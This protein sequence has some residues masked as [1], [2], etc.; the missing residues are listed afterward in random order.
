VFGVLLPIGLAAQLRRGGGPIATVQQLA[1]ITASL[2]IATLLALKAHEWLLVAFWAA[3]TAAI[4]ALHPA[5][6]RLLARPRKPDPILAVVA[7]LA[8]VPAAIYAAQMAANH[9]AGLAGDETN[10][11]EHWTVDKGGSGDLSTGWAAG[12][13]EWGVVVVLAVA[14]APGR[15]SG[16]WR[17][18]RRRWWSRSRT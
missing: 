3:V 13:L 12:A 7:A 1:V 10:S 9:R 11:F 14:T 18:S 8:L 16:R 6:R 5:R 15:A 17:S 4:A 2:A